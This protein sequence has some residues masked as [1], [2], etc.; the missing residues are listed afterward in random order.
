MNTEKISQSISESDLKSLIQ[1]AVQKHQLGQLNEAQSLY[2]QVLQIEP[3]VLDEQDTF[4]NQYYPIAVSNL[5]TIFEQQGE[6]ELAIEYYEQA[7]ELKPDFGEVYY[8]LGNVFLQQ[9]KLE[10][11]IES[12]QQALRIKPNYPQAH[13]N[14][15]NV[16]QLQG[17]LDAAYFMMM[18]TFSLVFM[19]N[20]SKV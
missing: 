16:F 9:G 13:N 12:Y 20:S 6:L 17:K 5:G 3:Q 19:P 18:I 14:L 2:K 15:G 11:A 8:N 10:A 4:R 1:L 7:L